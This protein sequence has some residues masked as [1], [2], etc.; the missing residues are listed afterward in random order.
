MILVS[1]FSFNL[2][3]LS[4]NEVWS[5]NAITVADNGIIGGPAR[6]LFIDRN[7]TIFIGA[8]QK[9]QILIWPKDSVTPTYIINAALS[10]YSP[11]FVTDAADI[12]FENGNKGGQVVK[13]SL[14]LNRTITVAQF[15]HHCYGLFITDDNAVYCSQYSTHKVVRFFLNITH[16]N[17][18]IVA[19]TGDSGNAMSQLNGPWGIYVDQNFSLFVADFWN[20]RIQLF[21]SGQLNGTIV[22]GQGVPQGLKL[23][24]PTD[25]T[26]DANNNM[27]IGD[28][29]NGR[30]IRVS[31]SQWSCVAACDG[32]RDDEPNQFQLRDAY[33][34]R[35][36][37]HGNIYVGDEH[38]NR[39]QKFLL[40]KNLSSKSTY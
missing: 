33:I 39:I 26:F 22:A 9:S 2:V 4:S 17:E 5:G 36:D 8:Y 34:I 27:Y 30:V 29:H 10:E 40:Q 38:N 18:A 11:I 31:G 7:D 13:W 15:E 14:T 3:N 19:G 28:A 37:S 25:V 21:K 32:K 12:Y 1:A 24:R 16:E 35:F 6:A 20:N 23:N